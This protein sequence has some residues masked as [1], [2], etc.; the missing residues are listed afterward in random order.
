MESLIAKRSKNNKS[1]VKGVCRLND[2]WVSY[3]NLA[4]KRYNLGSY[5]K[6]E[7]AK[8]ARKQAE[9]ELFFPIIEKAYK[10]KIDEY[11]M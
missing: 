10:Q 4:G 2:K 11:K 9:K 5:K 8:K 3:I 1:G 7:D 6:L